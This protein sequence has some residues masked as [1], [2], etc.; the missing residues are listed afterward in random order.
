MIFNKLFKRE[1]EPKKPRRPTRDPKARAKENRTKLTRKMHQKMDVKDL[2]VGM[3]VV[4]LDI[5]WEQSPFMFQSIEL[6][7]PA[8]VLAVQDACSY[9]YVDYDEFSLQKAG[10]A[11]TGLPATPRSSTQKYDVDV[12][13]EYENAQEVHALANRTVSTLFEEIRLGADVDSSKVKQAVNGCVESIVRNPDASVWLT[14][15]QAKSE[16]TAQHSMNVA[17]LSIIIGKSVN[18]SQRELEDV[19][20]CGML[21]DVGKT[22]VSSEVISKPG[23][24][25]EEELI[26]MR[27]HCRYGRDILLSTK[28]V[29]SGAA[30]VAHAHHERVDGTGYPRSLDDDRI[31]K[32]AKIVAIAE[33]YDTMTT[34]QVYR[35]AISPSIALQELYAARGT[36]FD[37]EFVVRFIDA[38]GIFPPGSIIEMVNGEVGIVLANT[39]DKL[40]PRVIMILDNEKEAALQRI[41]DLS[42]METDD[43][44][45]VYQIKTTHS[46]GAFGIDIADFQRAGLRIG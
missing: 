3:L 43:N 14:R 38:I 20:A 4:E 15:I 33:A 29:L 37:E 22:G 34:R 6:K 5:P 30:D 36:Q 1:E 16:S 19:G 24:L 39:T 23:P 25:N 28:S 17:A 46:D 45:D 11:G 31:P 41:V 7:S 10:P 12:E 8:D 44:G 9:V 13:D 2:R 32:Y 35:D 21:H 42:Q 26:E 18:M 27:K 40:R